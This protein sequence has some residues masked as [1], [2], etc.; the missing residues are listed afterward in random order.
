MTADQV[1]QTLVIV[2]SVATLVFGVSWR[3]YNILDAVKVSVTSLK[4]EVQSDVSAVR[5]DVS[6]LRTS[7][8]G[9]LALTDAQLRAELAAI[10]T[11]VEHHDTAIAALRVNRR[12]STAA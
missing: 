9:K 8:D 1:W 5:A 11:T 7:I 12:R 4:S 6:L 3:L 10:K 2:G